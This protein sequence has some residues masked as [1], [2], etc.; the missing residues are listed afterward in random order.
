MTPLTTGERATRFRIGVASFVRSGIRGPVAFAALQTLLISVMG[1]I[2]SLVAQALVARLLGVRGYGVYLIALAAMNLALLIAKL[3]IDTC[4]IRYVGAYAGSARWGLLGGFVRTSQRG[5]LLLAMLA[6]IIGAV[7]I[8]FARV[9]LAGRD[10]ALTG[11][12]WMACALLPPTGI[13][14]LNSAVLQGLSRYL[15]AQLPWQVL[16]PL[17]VI[18]ALLWLS[19]TGRA[20]S[21]TVAITCNVLAAVLCLIPIYRALWRFMPVEIRFIEPRFE[22]SEWRRTMIGMFIVSISQFIISQPSDVLIVGILLGPRESGLYGAAAQL[23][24]SIDIATASVLFVAAPMIASIFGRGNMDELQRLVR[25]VNRVN[26]LVSVPVSLLVI[27]GGRLLLSVYGSAFV[28]AF[29]A[30][31]VLVAAQLV[32]GVAGGVA[33]YLL[34]MTNQQKPAA[35]IIGSSA[36]F[37]LVLTVVLTPR[38]GIVGTA[39]ATLIGVIVRSL[40]LE[41]YIRTRMKL[42]L[43]TI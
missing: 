40:I 10:P 3:E 21:P 30:M 7:V 42:R 24:T 38:F 34:T 32:G 19:A 4:A 9:H 36:V 33:G 13:L 1:A 12:L 6:S 11:A 25:T 37:A 27:M 31:A 18:V 43:L 15:S 17:V 23:A 39:V 41:F 20:I 26:I 22:Y 28:Q 16:R 35:W 2:C 8:W 29:T 14:L 5:V